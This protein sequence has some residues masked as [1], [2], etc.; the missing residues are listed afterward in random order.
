MSKEKNEKVVE[1]N[2][3]KENNV[4]ETQ[5]QATV[6]IEK[7]KLNLIAAFKALKWWQ[8][9]MIIAGAGTLVFVGGK[10]IFKV[11]KGDSKIVADAAAEA[12]PV[13]DVVGAAVEVA[14]EVVA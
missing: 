1:I 12:I 14:T 2:E 7:E 13:E 8:K 11:V 9:A 6:E 10:V 3:V 5:E 4:E